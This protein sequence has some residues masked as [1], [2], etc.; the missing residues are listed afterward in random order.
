MIAPRAA[1][2]EYGLNDEV[3]NTWGDEQAYNSALKVYKLLG[4]PDRLGHHAR[5]GLSRRQRSGDVPGLAGHPVRPIHPHLDQQS[6]VP[7]GFRSSGALARK[8][9]VDLSRYPRHSSRRRHRFPRRTGRR[10][11]TDIR[12]SVEW[13]LGDEPAMMP[14][15]AGRGGRGG[16]AHGS[17]AATAP[18][19]RG[20]GNPGQT[21][22]DLVA[23][24]IQRGG[25]SFGWLE[26]QKSQTVS[27]SVSFGYNVRGDLYLSRRNTRPTPSCRP[28]SGCTGTAIRSATCGSITTICIRSWRWS[29]PATPSWLSIRAASEAA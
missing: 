23:W 24:V 10:R 14:P 1:L 27:R 25:N 15:A 21:L 22:P 18:G 7:V 5:A 26:P 20:V 19:A 8:E 12:K 11:P 3:S 13:M 29:G 16:R 6:A 2:I 28:S 4:Q 17:G 9:T